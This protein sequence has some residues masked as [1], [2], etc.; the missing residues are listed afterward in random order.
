MTANSAGEEL[1]AA[2]G[3]PMSSEKSILLLGPRKPTPIQISLGI[4]KIPNLNSR[5][6][7]YIIPYITP[8]KE[9]SLGIFENSYKLST[10]P[11]GFLA[12]PRKQNLA[13]AAKLQRDTCQGAGAKQAAQQQAEEPKEEEAQQQRLCPEHRTEEAKCY[14]HVGRRIEYIPVP[15]ALEQQN[16]IPEEQA[17]FEL[18]DTGNRH[19]IHS[20]GLTLKSLTKGP[21][22]GSP[23]KRTV[24]YWGLY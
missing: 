2:Y 1:R 11:L 9:F 23:K 8:F 14:Q 21:F 18:Q 24:F 22:W 19:A 7:P 16:V 20:L 10:L 13:A 5:I 12:P 4:S 6:V 17:A 15:A 3:R